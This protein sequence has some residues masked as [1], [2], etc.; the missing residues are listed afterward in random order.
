MM[1]VAAA[2]DKLK[3]KGLPDVDE[4]ALVGGR[5]ADSKPSTGAEV[6]PRI[7]LSLRCEDGKV[8]GDWGSHQRGAGASLGADLTEVG[9]LGCGGISEA[10]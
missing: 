7:R 5:E 6:D 3:E 9:G 1:L 8:E 2:Q 10:A 4:T